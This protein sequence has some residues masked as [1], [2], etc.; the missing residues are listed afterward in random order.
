MLVSGSYDATVVVWDVDN[1]VQKLKLQVIF[2]TKFSVCS[3]IY[4]TKREYIYI[5]KM[6]YETR[7]V[8]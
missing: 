1:A 6:S 7:A 3:M 8:R 4:V 5:R 2:P